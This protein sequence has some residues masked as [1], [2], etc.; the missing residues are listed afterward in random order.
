MTATLRQ[1]RNSW[2]IVEIRLVKIVI[3]AADYWALNPRTLKGGVGI[4]VTVPFN[5][6]ASAMPLWLSVVP[7]ERSISTNALA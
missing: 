4:F 5:A 2:D 3:V 1:A 6:S 7:M